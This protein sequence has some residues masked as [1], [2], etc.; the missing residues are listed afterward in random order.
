MGTIAIVHQSKYPNHEFKLEALIGEQKKSLE[1]DRSHLT[2]IFNTNL[3][4]DFTSPDYNPNCH[5]VCAYN[6]IPMGDK[7]I[8]AHYKRNTAFL[9]EDEMPFAEGQQEL[10]TYFLKEVNSIFERIFKAYFEPN[11]IFEKF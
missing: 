11:I 9:P 8:E 10:F 6:R 5:V 1:Y 7:F 2:S 3:G 4:A